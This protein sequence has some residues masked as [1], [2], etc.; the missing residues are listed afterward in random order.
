[1]GTL[2]KN[3]L[4]AVLSEAGMKRIRAKLKAADQARKKLSREYLAARKKATAKIKK[5][6]AK[7]RKAQ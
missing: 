7:R 6:F 1:M 5:E 2:K 4:K 3:F